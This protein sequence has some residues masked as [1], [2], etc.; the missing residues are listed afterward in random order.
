MRRALLPEWCF[1]QA[2]GDASRGT[3]F[4]VGFRTKIDF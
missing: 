4:V 3:F 1:V 2:Q